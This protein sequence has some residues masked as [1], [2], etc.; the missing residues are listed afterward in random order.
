M[1]FENIS[2]KELW[3]IANSF[4]DNLMDGSTEINHAKHT[5]DFTPRL[6]KIVTPDNLKS[7]CE[8]YQKDKGY[9]SNR[10]PVAVIKRPDAAAFI[11]KQSF[12][13]AK[14]DFVAEMLLVHRAGKFLVEHVMVF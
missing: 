11:W 10:E 4:M 3:K 2:D 9:F 5:R 6:L 1:N 12:T 13:K 8:S 14:G 7:M